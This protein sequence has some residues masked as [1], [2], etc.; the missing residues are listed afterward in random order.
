M[1]LGDDRRAQAM[2]I[3]AVLLFGVLVLAFINYQVEHVPDQNREVEFNHF[4][5]VQDDMEVLRN[6]VIQAGQMGST[7]PAG[8]DLGTTYPGGCTAN[9]RPG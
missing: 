3:G 2:Q 6:A 7:V 4:K 1:D 9:N 8:I 5:D